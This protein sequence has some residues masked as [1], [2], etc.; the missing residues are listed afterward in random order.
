MIA[1]TTAAR[2]T[3][4]ADFQV[5]RPTWGMAWP[6]E[7]RMLGT[8]EGSMVEQGEERGGA[9]SASEAARGGRLSSGRA[10]EADED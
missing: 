7:R 5:P 9:G 6:E 10:L 1:S 2:T 8:A 4:G 3:P